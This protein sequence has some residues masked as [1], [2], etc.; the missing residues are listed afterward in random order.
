M[1]PATGVAIAGA[2]ILASGAAGYVLRSKPSSPTAQ[3][4][5]ARS[6]TADNIAILDQAASEPKTVD[7]AVLASGFS[8]SPNGVHPSAVKFARWAHGRTTMADFNWKFHPKTTHEAV[9][10]DADLERGKR[11]CVSG[12]VVQISGETIDGKRFYEA[13]IV[14]NSVKGTLDVTRVV[15]IG[16]VTD[17][18]QGREAMFCGIV[19]GRETYPNTGGG[20]SHAVRL[21]GMFVTP[22]NSVHAIP[23]SSSE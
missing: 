7:E 15:A 23:K 8:D 19:V 3:Q 22:A 9:M 20:T 13:G 16:D 1:K 17:I 21:V 6:E 4:E 5:N 12:S 2:A 11:L 18:F 10:R 14:T